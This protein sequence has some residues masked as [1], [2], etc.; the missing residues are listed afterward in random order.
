MPPTGCVGLAQKTADVERVV[1]TLGVGAE[2]EK[3]EVQE[4]QMAGKRAEEFAVVTMEQRTTAARQG[5]LGIT[6]SESRGQAPAAVESAR[7]PATLAPY[8]RA[9]NGLTE[10]RVRTTPARDCDHGHFMIR[11]TV[12]F[13][14]HIE[15]YRAVGACWSVWEVMSVRPR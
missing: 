6:A 8:A 4:V 12:S 14:A 15:L 7:R 1:Y 9:S 13:L 5:S 11:T 3:E 2:K 10:D